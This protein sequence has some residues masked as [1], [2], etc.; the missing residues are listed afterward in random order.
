L[1]RVRSAS[2]SFDNHYLELPDD[3][4]LYKGALVVLVL[5]LHITLAL[6]GNLFGSSL[7]GRSDIGSDPYTLKAFGLTF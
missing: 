6:H 2:I 4:R 7:A 5:L 1:Y 3:G